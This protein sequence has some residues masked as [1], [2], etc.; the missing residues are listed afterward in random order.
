MEPAVS[1]QRTY[2]HLQALGRKPGDYE[3][4]TSRLLYHPQKGFEVDTPVA[5]WYRR[6]Q[7]ASPLRC[8]DWEAF[9]DP[10]AYTYTSYV[11]RRHEAE[12]YLDGLLRSLDD[13]DYDRT[14]TPEWLGFLEQ[15]LPTLRYPGHALQMA[16]AYV[17]QMAPAGRIAIAA[18]FQAADEIRRIQRLSYRMRQLQET[19]RGFGEGARQIWEQAAAWQPLRALLER[20]LVAYDWGESFVALN[21]AVKPAFDELFMVRFGQLARSRGDDRLQGMFFS[22]G[23]DCAWQRQWSGCLLQVACGGDAGSRAA[24][25]GWFEHWLPRSL[26]AIQAL[27][28]ELGLGAGAAEA[29]EQQCRKNF[30]A[31]VAER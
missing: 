2:W 11:T 28:D 10:R 21:F 18:A 27:V 3:I 19:R 23:E 17:G 1:T 15:V 30:A 8:T 13:G 20:L 12:M 29:I 4:A 6:Y 7:T 16:A 22:L 31:A 24:A 25:Q 14:L 9:A 26:G 5:A